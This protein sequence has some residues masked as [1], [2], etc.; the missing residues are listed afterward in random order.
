MLAL[1]AL[2]NHD[3]S[4]SLYIYLLSISLSSSAHVRIHLLYCDSLLLL[5]GG[6]KWRE[7]RAQ[8]NDVAGVHY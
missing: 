6:R 7:G 8:M 3:A 4:L 2:A 1:L 5:V